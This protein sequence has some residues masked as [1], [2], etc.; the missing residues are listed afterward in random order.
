MGPVT[1]GGR[2]KGDETRNTALREA[3]AQSS[4]IG[5]RSITIGGLADSLGMSKSGVYA[6]FRSKEQLQIA[7]LD[8]AAEV[9]TQVVLAPALAEP[10]G[11]PRLRA[12]VERWL[13]WDG[14]A[15]YALPGGCIFVT[16]AREY[17]D[18]PASPVRDRIVRQQVDWLTSLGQIVQGGIREGHFRAGLDTTA[19]A[20]DLYALMLGYHFAAR[21]LRDPEA[22]AR[23]LASFERLLT[24]LHP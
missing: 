13:G 14:Y 4:H 23:A 12:L 11:E 17:D 19:V 2:T 7:V 24:D 6:H 18:E 15:D 1:T 21:L 8:L 16:V 3:L 5:L 9:F 10:R 20:H 22:A